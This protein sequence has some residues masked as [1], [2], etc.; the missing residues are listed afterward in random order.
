MIAK[1]NWLLH[2]INEYF[3]VGMAYH[4]FW[5]NESIH[6][7]QYNLVRKVTISNQ[8]ALALSGALP[9][10]IN[11]GKCKDTMLTFLFHIQVHCNRITCKHNTLIFNGDILNE[12]KWREQEIVGWLMKRVCLN[13]DRSRIYNVTISYSIILPSMLSIYIY[14]YIYICLNVM[15]QYSTYYKKTIIHTNSI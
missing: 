8:C 14:I 11:K 7:F 6:T 4:L 15:I 12:L 10:P 2:P 3:Y 5:Q 13:V 1:E 9:L